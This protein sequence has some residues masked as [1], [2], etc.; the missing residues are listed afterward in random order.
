MTHTAILNIFKEL[1]PQ[2]AEKSKM[3]VP[4]GRSCIRVKMDNK[5]EFIF[6]Y[7]GN[8]HWSLET[9]GCYIDRIKAKEDKK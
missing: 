5:S 4:N 3:W 8:G 6:T 9:V 7:E 2:Y 1:F